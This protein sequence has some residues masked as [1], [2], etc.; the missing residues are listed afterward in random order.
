MSTQTLS[1]NGGN[2]PL[3]ANF[4]RIVRGIQSQKIVWLF[5]DMQYGLGFHHGGTYLSW[6]PVDRANYNLTPKL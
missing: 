4:T 1:H 5:R 3:V 6:L 2:R